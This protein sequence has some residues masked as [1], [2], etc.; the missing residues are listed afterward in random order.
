[1][2]LHRTNLAVLAFLSLV[3]VIALTSV[4]CSPQT[5]KAAVDTAALTKDVADLNQLVASLVPRDGQTNQ[6]PAPATSSLSAAA[7]DRIFQRVSSLRDKYQAGPIRVSGFSIDFAI[8]P[9][10]TLQFEFK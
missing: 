9:G 3:C 4:S 1:M 10:V 7:W 6:F 8:P 5:V 2:R